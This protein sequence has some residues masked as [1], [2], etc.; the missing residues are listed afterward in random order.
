MKGIVLEELK[1]K[2]I[3]LT[4]EGD[5]IKINDLN[6]DLKVGEEILIEEEKANTKHIIRRFALAAA[7]FVMVML[8]SYAFYGY[9]VTQGYVSIGINPS[10]GKNVRMKIA[11]N[12]FGKTIKLQALNK[13]G[14]TIIEKMGRVQFKSTDEATNEFIKAAK[15]ESVISLGVDNTIVITITAFNKKIDDESMDRSV[16]R[17]IKENQIKGKVMIV[18][19]NKTDY[20]KAKEDGVPIDKFILINKAIEKNSTYKFDDL[21]KKSIEEIINIINEEEKNYK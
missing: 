4:E 21:N 7:M 1:N 20:E 17:Y 2:R 19:G 10:L 13:E 11:Y 5:F 9:F 14:N 6:R 3:V 15:K 8:S 12:Y 16:E 18:L